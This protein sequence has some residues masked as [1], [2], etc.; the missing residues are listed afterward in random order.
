[1]IIGLLGGLIYMGA[2]DLMGKLKIDDP[3]EAFPVH[4]ACGIWGVLAVPLDGTRAPEPSHRRP[5]IACSL[6]ST[7]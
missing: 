6:R 2:G 3:V 5:T 7:E 4:G 1:M